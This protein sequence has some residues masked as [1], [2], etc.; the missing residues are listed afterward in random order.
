MLKIVQLKSIKIYPY[1]NIYNVFSINVWTVIL[2]VKYMIKDKVY[3]FRGDNV[4][5]GH[6]KNHA[7]IGGVEVSSNVLCDFESLHEVNLPAMTRCQI[8]GGHLSSHAV[9]F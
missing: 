5:R 9:I 6:I 2:T 1:L 8:S 3:S 4:I 7:K